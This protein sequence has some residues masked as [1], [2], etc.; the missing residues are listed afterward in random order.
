MHCTAHTSLIHRYT[1]ELS[2][3]WKERSLWLLLV[4]LGVVLAIMQIR[5][6]LTVFLQYPTSST[7]IVAN[8]NQVRF[9]QV[10]FCNENQMKKSV[11]DK[12]GEKSRTQQLRCLPTPYIHL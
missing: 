9:P 7:A 4:L 2:Y 10:T 3:T 8:N 6:R 5:D 12:A 11:A 1:V